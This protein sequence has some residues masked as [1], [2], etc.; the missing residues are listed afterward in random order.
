MN[1]ETSLQH[2]RVCARCIRNANVLF[3]LLPYPFALRLPTNNI[4]SAACKR[5]YRIWHAIWWNEKF[6]QSFLLRAHR[7][8]PQ[9]HTHT[10]FHVAFHLY[11]DAH[12][13]LSPRGIATLWT[14]SPNSRLSQGIVVRRHTH[15]HITS[16]GLLLF[17]L[18]LMKHTWLVKR[19]LP[20]S[21]FEQNNIS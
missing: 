13:P 6:S 12:P 16:V 20:Q 11:S 2:C 17:L 21:T 18:L 19:A 3:T 10:I 9:A 5:T 14:P 1:K 15:A 7:S 8:T 4:S